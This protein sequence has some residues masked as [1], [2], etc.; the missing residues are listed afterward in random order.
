MLIR[1]CCKLFIYIEQRP[2]KGV[3]N[4][5][6]KGKT[7][8][9]SL[10]PMSSIWGMWEGRTPFFYRKRL[11]WDSNKSYAEVEC[12]CQ[13]DLSWMNKSIYPRKQKGTLIPRIQRNNSKANTNNHGD[14][15]TVL[16]SWVMKPS[17]KN[18]HNSIQITWSNTFVDNG[19]NI[20]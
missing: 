6:E 18:Q 7:Q 12:Y 3:L 20:L 13:G 19:S 15:R 5:R 8:E 4:N 9:I 17:S 2:L 14:R 16:K 11:L 1:M 10:L